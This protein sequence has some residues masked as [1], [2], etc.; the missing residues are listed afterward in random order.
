MK[1]Y[2]CNEYSLIPHFYIV[3]MGF[4]GVQIYL[5]S[6]T[7]IV[8]TRLK[9]LVKN[10]RNL[11]YIGKKGCEMKGGKQQWFYQREVPPGWGFQWVFAGPKV[12]V[13]A[14]PQRWVGEGGMVTN[15]YC[16]A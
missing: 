16:S 6:K 1:T 3:K 2:L 15:D 5:C 11:L 8:G 9:R 12:K 7:K 14:I 4:C 10:T 13:H